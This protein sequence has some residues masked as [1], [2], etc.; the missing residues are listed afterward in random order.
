MGVSRRRWWEPISSSMVAAEPGEGA[1]GASG[2]TSG[3]IAGMLKL[4]GFLRRLTAKDEGQTL[5][6]YGLILFFIAVVAVFAVT[7]L[8]ERVSE[9]FDEIR[10]ALT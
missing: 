4:M 2:M 7:L 5:T 8:G 1:P 10:Q 3:G 9:M 6:E